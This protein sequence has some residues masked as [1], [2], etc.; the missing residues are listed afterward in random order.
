MG[1]YPAPDGTVWFTAQSAGKLGR[2]DQRTGKSDLIALG[3]GAAPACAVPPSSR[4]PHASRLRRRFRRHPRDAP[5]APDWQFARCPHRRRRGDIVARVLGARQRERRADGFGCRKISPSAELMVDPRS[6]ARCAILDTR[7]AGS[8]RYH[9]TMTV[10][11]TPD[12]V[13][14]GRTS[15]AVAARSQ[16]EAA[17]DA[18]WTDERDYE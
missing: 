16:A 3:P 15:D 2:L 13:T 14:A 10:V 4:A 18:Y 6:G 7:P 1:V 9:W 8:E 5:N 12:T 17:V 11:G